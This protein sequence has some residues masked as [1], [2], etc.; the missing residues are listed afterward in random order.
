VTSGARLQQA[1]L[2]QVEVRASGRI[3]KRPKNKPQPFSLPNLSL[4][5]LAICSSF[6]RSDLGALHASFLS[7]ITP[8]LVHFL[9]NCSSDMLSFR[10][11][12]SAKPTP[13]CN[14]DN[15]LF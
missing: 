9:Q 12:A 14:T 15:I 1:I 6:T 13:P 3:S 7:N 2:V 11:F 8:S 10:T 4:P 5:A